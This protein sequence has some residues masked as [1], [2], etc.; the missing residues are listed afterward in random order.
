MSTNPTRIGCLKPTSEPWYSEFRVADD[1]RYERL[2]FVQV[3]LM[4]LH[5]GTWRTCVWG[6]DDHGLEL[7]TPDEARAREVYVQVCL[8]RDVTHGA[9]KGLGFVHA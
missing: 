2:H 7:D 9:L 4:Q 5:D 1:K 6:N 3:S 8:M